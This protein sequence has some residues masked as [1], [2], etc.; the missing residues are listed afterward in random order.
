MADDEL[1]LEIPDQHD[2]PEVASPSGKDKEGGLVRG[3]TSARVRAWQ[4]L[5]AAAFA[6]TAAR[7]QPPPP[8]APARPQM[9]PLARVKKL[10]KAQEG[11]KLASTEA[12]FLIGR[13]TVSR[14]GAASAGGARSD[15][16]ARID[17]L[18]TSLGSILPA[19]IRFKP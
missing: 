12:I 19:R 13:A 7:R 16:I 5:R 3:A 9:L 4:P 17:H 14:A 2:D 15:H 18:A 11:V 8:P 6:P 1:Q 10:I